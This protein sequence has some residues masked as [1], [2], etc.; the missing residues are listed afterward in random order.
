MAVA[1]TGK[2]AKV[3]AGIVKSGSAKGDEFAD[4]S[5]K[6]GNTAVLR[7]QDIFVQEKGK[8]ALKRLEEQPAPAQPKVKGGAKGKKK[9]ASKSAAKEKKTIGK[10]AAESADVRKS[11]DKILK[12]TPNKSSSR[13]ETP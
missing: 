10:K 11:V 3:D 1:E 13:K 9:A 2:K 5:F 8:D 6:E 12:Y 7:L 4:F